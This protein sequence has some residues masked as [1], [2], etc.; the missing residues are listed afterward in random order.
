MNSLY[1]KNET[2]FAVL[3][4]IIYVVG[5]SIADNLSKSV[6]I[7]KSITTLFCIVLSCIIV[8]FIR[9]NKLF[10]YYGLC[11]SD[12]PAKKVLYYFPLFIIGTVNLWF[13]VKMNFTPI[14]T[15]FY[16][17]SMLFVGFLEEI[18]FRGF[19]FKSMCKNNVKTA[20][21]VSSLTFGIGHIV[22]L[23]NGSGAELMDNFCQVCYAVAIGF[24][25][26]TLFFR[27]KSLWPCIIMHS[28]FN[29]LSAF[30]NKEMAE[31]YRI[32][33]AITLIVISLGYSLFLIKRTPKP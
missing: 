23:V 3:F 24:L 20:I 28:V 21:V 17:L 7:E 9:K 26:V 29:L 31:L 13:G 27:G 16:V 22:N 1:K 19:L 10:T 6:G 12:L 4:I 18:I 15:L 32:P 33:I 30:S 8:L 14:E 11:K 2:W 25:F 5:M